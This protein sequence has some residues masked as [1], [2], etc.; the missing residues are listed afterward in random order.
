MRSFRWSLDT[1]SYFLCGEHQ[2]LQ[3]VDFGNTLASGSLD[4]EVG[5]WLI[6]KSLGLP[7]PEENTFVGKTIYM[8]Q[9]LLKHH[10]Y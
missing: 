10:H 1:E 5:V 6:N 2:S 7:G 4:T 3:Q 8:D 9:C